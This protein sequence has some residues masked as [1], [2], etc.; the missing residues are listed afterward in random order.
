MA[1]Y[2]TAAWAGGAL[3]FIPAELGPVA[4]DSM[5]LERAGRALVAHAHGQ[6]SLTESLVDGVL[7]DLDDNPDPQWVDCAA[8][9]AEIVHG[10]G[11]ESDT[12]FVRSILEPRLGS[13]AVVGAGL[14]NLG[15]VDRYV[16]KLAASP[17]ERAAHFGRAS[18]LA[19]SW[20]MPF[21]VE[22]NR[23]DA[24]AA[25]GGSAF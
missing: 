6:E 4:E 7:A 13:A 10:R 16:G 17:A 25:S 8:M 3:G 24:D 21:W 18:Q 22:A 23:S 1:Q 20:G 19:E 2:V 14:A 9:V 12:A 11:S 15:P 5:A